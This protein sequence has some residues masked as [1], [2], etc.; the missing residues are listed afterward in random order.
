METER[1]GLIGKAAIVT[2]GGQGIGKGIALALAEFGAD[3]IVAERDPETAEAA[4]AEIRGLGRKALALVTDVREPEQINNMVEKSVDEFGRVDILVNNAGGMFRADVASI[5]EGG[6]DAIIRINLKS[7]FLCCK[8]V[9][10]LM[11]EKKTGG[12][13]INISSVNGLSG[14][15]GSA[16]YG[17]AK[18]GIINFTQSLALELA[19]YGIRVNAIAPGVI[20]TPGT[21]QWMTPERESE[22]QKGIPLARRG[23]PEDI[24]GAAIYLVSDLADYVTG[25]TIVVDG[26][27]MAGSR[28]P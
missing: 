1:F 26:G 21:S 6:W 5:S 16:A 3:V 12:S 19:P 18:A 7:T 10:E 22:V 9:S 20:D 25:Q 28:V 27:L 4:A 14:T 13:I 17:A 2:G 8:A 23:K 24:A 15:P 11:V